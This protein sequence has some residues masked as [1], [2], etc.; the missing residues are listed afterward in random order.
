MGP[1]NEAE[2]CAFDGMTATLSSSSAAVGWAISLGAAMK[3]EM[4]Y[5]KGD[6][7]TRVKERLPGVESRLVTGYAMCLFFAEKVCD[8]MIVNCIM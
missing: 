8:C 2:S 3:S 5:I 7:F 4:L 6:L 1:Q